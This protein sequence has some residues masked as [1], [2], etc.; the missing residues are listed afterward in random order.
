MTVDFGFAALVSVGSSVFL[1]N[2][3]GGGNS[4]NGQ[5]DGSEPGIP[6][7]TVQLYDA[8]NVEIPVGP[9]G[10]LGTTDDAN[11]GV[12]TGAS[13]GYF[14]QGL[15]P[16]DYRVVI[17][18]PP[19]AAPLSST[20][21]TTSGADNQVDG[22]DNGLQPAGSGTIVRSPLINLDVDDETST[23][24]APGGGQDNGADSFGDMTI[25][26]GFV[27]PALVGSL[28]NYIWVDWNDNGVI[29]GGEPAAPAGVLLNLL[30][31]NG[32]PIPA[33]SGGNVTTVTDASGNYL[34]DGLS[35]GD[36]II[37]VDPS[38]FQSGG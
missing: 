21:T 34:F 32:A 9:D 13:G 26:F 20:D 27:S 3:A 22:D 10:I 8:S 1:D 7:I 6:G 2:G 30:D 14:F 36:Y 24:A 35:A 28:G 37:E 38:N 19:A 17:N 18:T 23:E 12:V 31:E 11:G 29:D 16:G 33:P 25:D 15:Q 4:N 5:R